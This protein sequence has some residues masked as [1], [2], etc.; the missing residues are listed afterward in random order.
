M[1]CDFPA[2]PFP[3]LHIISGQNL[4]LSRKVPTISL[5]ISNLMQARHVGLGNLREVSNGDISIEM[6]S[7]DL[8]GF[9][10]TIK[11]EDIIPGKNNTATVTP[12]ESSIVDT[13]DC[14]W[15]PAWYDLP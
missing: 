15:K 7:D 10:Y 1:D 3:N 9:S 5:L 8:T 6:N 11:W 4:I 13:N 12:S 2:L 14:K